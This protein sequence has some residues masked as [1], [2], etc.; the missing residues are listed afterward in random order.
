M[1]SVWLA[2][3]G[4]AVHAVDPVAHHVDEALAKAASAE[5]ALASAFVADARAVDLPDG[6]AD[7]VL[8]MG[9][10]YHLQDRADRLDATGRVDIVAPVVLDI[11]CFRV[12]PPAG[13]GDA[14]SEADLDRFQDEL[15]LRI[16]ESGEAVP[17]N[18]TLTDGRSCMRIALCN[19]RTTGA[20]L[21]RF[22]EV[23]MRLADE[24]TEDAVAWRAPGDEVDPARSGC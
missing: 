1:Y 21:D 20:D 10:L 19:H 9:P 2:Q 4:Y 12:R 23:L 15:L 24:L 11:V 22:V 18:T 8:L 16:Q 14:P 6:C 5:V 3:H 7:A 17:S 13:S